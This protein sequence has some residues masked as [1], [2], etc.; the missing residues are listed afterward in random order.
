MAPPVHN[1]A[2]DIVVL[3]LDDPA[4]GCDI[5]KDI[6]TS[7]SD[8]GFMMAEDYILNDPELSRDDD[9]VMLYRN[10]KGLTHYGDQVAEKV[11]SL[12]RERAD[13]VERAMKG[14][15]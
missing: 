3:M 12:L 5:F 9:M 7:G 4:K 2:A 14:Q 1:Y 10:H 13:A 6:W 15:R 11:G 8:A